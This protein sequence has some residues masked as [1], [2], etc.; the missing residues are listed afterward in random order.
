MRLD[1]RT[2]GNTPLHLEGLWD[3]GQPG[4]GKWALS[5]CTE[6]PTLPLTAQDHPD[7][8]DLLPAPDPNSDLSPSLS[9][10][11]TLLSGHGPKALPKRRGRAGAATL[12]CNLL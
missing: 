8:E 6:S 7:R 5:I 12:L 4:G 3:R 11:G 10:E 9:P 2:T 1:L